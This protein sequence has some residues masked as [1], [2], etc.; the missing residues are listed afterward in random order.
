MIMVPLS[1]FVFGTIGVK[2]GS[3]ILVITGYSSKIFEFLLVTVMNYLRMLL[4]PLIIE[5][6]GYDPVIGDL[7]LEVSG[8][9]TSGALMGWTAMV[10]IIWIYPITKTNFGQKLKNREWNEAIKEITCW[11]WAKERFFYVG[12]LIMTAAMVVITIVADINNFLV[13]YYPQIELALTGQITLN[14]DLQRGNPFM[15]H[16]FGLIVGT[17][18]GIQMQRKKV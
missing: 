15:G 14:L 11:K 3:L 17:T 9:G 8:H 12:V 18:I 4:H 1:I 5:R 6:L 16:I 10:F 13:I 7:F 2:K